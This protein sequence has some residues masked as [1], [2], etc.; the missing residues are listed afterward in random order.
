MRR[1]VHDLLR[2][3]VASEDTR[4]ALTRGALVEEQEV[5]GFAAV[6]GMPAKRKARER[7]T[8]TK[9]ARTERE[10]KKRRDR[11]Q[12]Y[13]PSSPRPRG[14]S[15]MPRRL[16]APQSESGRKRSAPSIPRGRARATEL[17]C[18]APSG[19]GEMTF[20]YFGGVPRVPLRSSIRRPSR[21]SAPW[22]PSGLVLEPA[23]AV[24]EIG[25]VRSAHPWAQRARTAA[26][27]LRSPLALAELRLAHRELVARDGELRL[28]PRER[29]FG[30]LERLQ[31]R[32]DLRE[33][34][35]SSTTTS[36]APSERDRPRA[37]RSPPR[38]LR[39]RPPACRAPARGGEGDLSMHERLVG[40]VRSGGPSLRDL[41]ERVGELRSRRS[42]AATRSPARSAGVRAPALPRGESLAG[43]A[44]P[45]GSMLESIRHGRVGPCVDDIH[46]S[47]VPSSRFSVARPL[48]G[49]L[50]ALFRARAA[51]DVLSLAETQACLLASRTCR[52]R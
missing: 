31:A 14:C 3:A 11:E 38:A 36:P 23:E 37:R 42:T 6:P 43:A 27:R 35:S 41:R 16:S 9:D 44:A 20:A 12:L 50:E 39:A 15:W 51:N 33:C 21:T 28:R 4:A 32:L 34:S 5:A 30:L 49:A 29:P 40:S 26:D 10:E 46:A 2:R 22:T 13:E 1:R 17:A 19:R 25:D 24:V 48:R 8:S 45:F 47:D 7:T 18:A 52:A